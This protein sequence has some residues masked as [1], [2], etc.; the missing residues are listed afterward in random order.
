MGEHLSFSL[1]LALSVSVPS[2][3]AKG[4]TLAKPIRVESGIVS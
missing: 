3:F 1:S 4:G 2:E